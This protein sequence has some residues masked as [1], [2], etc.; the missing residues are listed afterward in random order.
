MAGP[1]GVYRARR[2]SLLRWGVWDSSRGCWVTVWG[3]DSFPPYK[4][5]AE[6]RTDVLNLQEA[7]EKAEALRNVRDAGP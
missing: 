2:K 1:D 7:T 5:V 3:A 6:H 4:G